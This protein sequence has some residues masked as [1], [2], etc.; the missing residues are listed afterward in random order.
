V[1]NRSL[2]AAEKRAALET[3]ADHVQAVLDGHG[4]KAIS[5]REP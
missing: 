2:Y 1:Y 4:Q 5:A 3:W